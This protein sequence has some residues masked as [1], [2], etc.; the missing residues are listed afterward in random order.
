[1]TILEERE[2]LHAIANQMGI[3]FAMIESMQIVLEEQPHPNPKLVECLEKSQRAL[4]K[5]RDQLGTR[6][7][8]LIA[9]SPKAA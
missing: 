8:K 4:D 5:M 7:S 6:R 2:F 1:M 9:A 3:L